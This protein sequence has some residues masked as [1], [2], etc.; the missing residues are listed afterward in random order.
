MAKDVPE[1][2]LAELGLAALRHIFKVC[3][4]LSEREYLHHF[5]SILLPCGPHD[6]E[7]VDE[8][9][10]ATASCREQFGNAK[11]DVADEE[12]VDAEFSQ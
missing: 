8:P 6:E 3:V 4:P 9:P 12:S 7:K 5:L 1:G 11:A 10:Y 2:A